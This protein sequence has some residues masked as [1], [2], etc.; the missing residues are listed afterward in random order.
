MLTS[1]SRLPLNALPTFVTAA[2][3]QNLRAASQAL[4]LTHSAVSQQIGLLEERLGFPLFE[5]R[6]RRIVLNAAGEAL[7]QGVAPALE[8]VQQAVSAASLAAHGACQTLRVTM[9]PSFAQRWFLPRMASWR[10]RHPDIVLDI[11][12]TFE[13]VDLTRD[14]FHAGIRTGTG[15]WPGLTAERLYSVPSPLIAVGSPAAR[16]RLEPLAPSRLLG[17]PLLGD[18]DLWARWFAAAGVEAEPPATVATFNDLSVML[19]AVEQDLGLA[20]VRELF[21]ADA[22]R[23][24][25]LERLG[26]VSFVHEGARSHSLVYPTALAGWPPLEALRAWLRSEFEDSLRGLAAPDTRAG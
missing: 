7:L 1:M 2:R 25:R 17:E 5:R 13:V 6:G 8:R 3:L 4:H 15:P 9:I 11:D 14:G 20:V 22:L 23:A 21:A 18:R 10:A 24:G 26:D 19:T 16:A 12:A